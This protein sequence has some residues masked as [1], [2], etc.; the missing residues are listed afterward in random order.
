M[1]SLKHFRENP[2]FSN[3]VLEKKY[4]LPKD[5]QKA[6]A[7]GSITAEMR[8]FDIEQLIESVS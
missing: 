6:P 5:A 7:D 2:Y 4:E 8:D 3:S 1:S